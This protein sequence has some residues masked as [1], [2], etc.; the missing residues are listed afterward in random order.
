MLS[1]STVGNMS[2]LVK[3]IAWHRAA[4]SHFLN[5]SWPSCL[6]PYGIPMHNVLPK[7]KPITW[8][9]MYNQL[10]NYS[11]LKNSTAQGKV[12]YPLN[13]HLGNIRRLA[14]QVNFQWVLELTSRRFRK[15]I[16]R[17]PSIPLLPQHIMTSSNGNIFRV[18][19][20]LC[21]EFTG[22]GEF[23]AQRPV[24]RSFNVFFDLR[25]NKR[26]SKQSWGW[27]FEILPCPLWCHCNEWSTQHRRWSHLQ[28]DDK[29]DTASKNLIRKY[30]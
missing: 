11:L 14:D 16:F 29:F 4:T 8:I 23:P 1:H 19:G 5:L 30:V 7:Y 3:V 28:I 24:T 21:G 10:A 2:A 18:T 12:F 15:S 6:T 26:L 9:W 20:H 13:G 27:W 17:N 25:P 22:P